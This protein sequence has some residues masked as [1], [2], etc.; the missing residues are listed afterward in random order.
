VEEASMSSGVPDHITVENKGT[1]TVRVEGLDDVDVDVTLHTPD[2]LR[3]DS[4]ID[5]TM[6]LA[7]TEPVTLNTNLKAELAISEPIVTKASTDVSL[8]VK[9]LVMDVC[10]TMKVADLPTQQVR[11]PYDH[12]FSVSVLGTELLAFRMCGESQVIIED[13]PIRPVVAWG[14]EAIRA[15]RPHVAPVP[16]SEPG[17]SSGLRVTLGD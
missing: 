1:T 9:P 3:S 17:G 5:S 10:L 13:L 7:V 4:K 2:A 15:H 14:A 16:S 8:D 12:R 11:R 6:A